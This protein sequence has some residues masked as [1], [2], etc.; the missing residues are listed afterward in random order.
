[1]LKYDI[2]HIVISQ[3]IFMPEK[4]QEKFYVSTDIP[5]K[6][7]EFKIKS[8]DTILNVLANQKKNQINPYVKD[9][10]RSNKLLENLKVG[11]IVKFEDH[12]DFFTVSINGKYD[13]R[14]D[15]EKRR[16]FKDSEIRK[17]YEQHDKELEKINTIKQK[18]EEILKKEIELSHKYQAKIIRENNGSYRIFKNNVELNMNFKNLE[19]TADA[20]EIIQKIQDLYTREFTETKP[21]F[22]PDNWSLKINDGFIFDT[23]YLSHQKMRIFMRE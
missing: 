5:Q 15:G 17:R 4:N 10:I 2:V 3:K 14:K 6:S 1:M 23:T 21:Q 11:D 20:L 13:L 16:F 9:F 8:G 18:E 22:Y 7:L 19:A 12:K